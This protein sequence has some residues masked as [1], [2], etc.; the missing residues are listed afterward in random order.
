VREGSGS[1]PSLE[2]TVSLKN[3]MTAIVSTSPDLKPESFPPN[4][5]ITNPSSNE[6]FYSY[7]VNVT[8]F[9]NPQRLVLTLVIGSQGQIPAR[10]GRIV[11]NSSDEKLVVLDGPDYS[12]F[13]LICLY[14][15][16][17]SLIVLMVSVS[18]L[19]WRLQSL[20]TLN[21]NLE[22]KL[23]ASSNEAME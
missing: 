18:I 23:A 8:Q 4:I 15:S 16:A 1:I 19:L 3:H 14:V 10:N 17:F 2:I 21:K 5:E 11:L 20:R 7:T 22:D 13:D 9:R 6:R 12:T